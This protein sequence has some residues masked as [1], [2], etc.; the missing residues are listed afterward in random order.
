M[1]IDYCYNKEISTYVVYMHS[2]DI[3]LSEV[4]RKLIFYNVYT[5]EYVKVKSHTRTL[6]KLLKKFATFHNIIFFK[7]TT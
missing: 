5:Y 2:Y 6:S 3:F 7:H 1:I 4:L